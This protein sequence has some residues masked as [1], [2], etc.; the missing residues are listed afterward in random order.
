MTID[1]RVTA[2]RELGPDV[3]ELTL[4]PLNGTPLPAFSPGSHVV[5]HVP[6]ER[7]RK[8]PYSLACAPWSTDAYR[9]AVRRLDDGRGGSR[10]VHERVQEGDVLAIEP[11]RNL[12]AP[13]VGARKHLLVAGGIGI[14]PFVSYA[15]QLVAA[16]VPFELHHAPAGGPLA[17]ELER[18]RPDAV[19]AHADRVA[20]MA[21]V[22]DALDAQPLGTHLSVC[23]PP[24]MME[25]VCAAAKR[26][27]WPGSRVHL[28]RFVL[29][30]G[31]MDP[32]AVRLARSGRELAVGADETLLEAL[33]AAGADV[34]YLC[35]QG[36]CGECRLDVLD[37]TPDHRDIYLTADERAAGAAIMP[38]VSRCAGDGPLVLD[39]A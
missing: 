15:H 3:R 6:G 11:P 1:V 35:R 17:D 24:A 20:L 21:A 36:I 27:G 5:V 18:L 28:E 38:C 2:V 12:F 22:E 9:I 8:N 14:T 4:A 10:A 30:T 19:R 37:G 13:V 29:D 25:A 34:P 32:F 23:G 16:G 7:T 31:P 26:H 33:E 39:L